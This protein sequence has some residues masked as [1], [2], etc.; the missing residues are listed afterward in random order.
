MKQTVFTGAACA[1]TTP[2]DENRNVDYKALR[3]QIDFQIE[4]GTDAL[5]VCGTTGEGSALNTRE[6]RQIIKAAVKQAAGRVPVI[7]GT[8]S[9][10]TETAVRLSN[11]AENVGADALLL[12]TPYY[13]KCSQE[14][15]IEHYSF[16]NDRV[17]LPM[18]VYN[19]PSRT[20]L[21]IKPETYLELSKI[22]RIVATKEANGSLSDLMKTVSLCGDSLDVFCGNDDQTAAFIAMGA[23]GVISVLSNIAPVFV[24]EITAAALSGNTDLSAS[25]Q[26]KYLELANV[27]FCDVNP[28]PVKYA[29]KKMEL[30]SG[31]CRLP[32]T[33]PS[34][35]AKFKIDR[36]LQKYG[37]IEAD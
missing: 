5:V 1:I 18:I 34:E 21:N 12:V 11:A 28:I 14:G 2:F 33:E 26:M 29:L 8:G 32:L 31:V 24:S 17:S 37:L 6:H 3:K 35:A 36:T 10:C 20:G 4:N 25:L 27:L 22:E 19:V 7:A 30:D 16:I 23:K 9:N 15:L 13:N